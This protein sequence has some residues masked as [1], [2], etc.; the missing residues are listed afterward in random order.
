M[1]FDFLI[2]NKDNSI[3]CLIEVDGVYHSKLIG[4]NAEERLEKRQMIDKI[5]NKYCKDNNIPLLR[6][7]YL[8]FKNIEEILKQYLIIKN[9]IPEPL[10][11]NDIQEEYDD[12]FEEDYYD[13][14]YSV[15][16]IDVITDYF[17]RGDLEGL[18]KTL[19]DEEEDAGD[20]EDNDYE[21]ESEELIFM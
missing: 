7:N 4:K 17:L 6:I 12:D 8:Q 3:F 19:E 13:D 11:L 2:L 5:K 16:Q 18:E 20:E 21:E 10:I 1:P 9:P 15:Y 14:I